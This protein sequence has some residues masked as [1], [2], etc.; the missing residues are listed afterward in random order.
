MD[1][2]KCPY[3]LSPMRS[4]KQL[5]QTLTPRQSRIYEMV[6]NA[7]PEGISTHDLAEQC[8]P[9]KKA[10]TLRTAIHAV[11]SKISPLRIK[12]QGGRCYLD[13]VNWSEEQ[14]D[15]LD[16]STQKSEKEE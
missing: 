13:R 5:L 1:E 16:H 9:G 10:G 12:T 3:C 15:I 7:G 4:L 11:N 8:I 6:V 2:I 14:I